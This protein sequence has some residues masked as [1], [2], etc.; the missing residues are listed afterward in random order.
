VRE[1]G[2]A[3]LL[4][5]HLL[6]QVQNVCDRIGIFAAGKLIGQGTMADL[7]H[8]FGDGKAHLEVGLE[9]TDDTETGRIRDVFAAIPGVESVR[10]S[11]R[12]SQPWDLTVASVDQE[13]RVRTAV[14]E[15]VAREHLPLTSIQAVIPSLEDIY[16]RAVAGDPRGVRA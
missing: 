4:S 7:A 11:D 5:S 6:N 15:I 14:L 16:R 10:I 13:A 3:I 2:M 12:P 8:K 9:G 1:R